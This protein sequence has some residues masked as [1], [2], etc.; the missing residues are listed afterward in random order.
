NVSSFNMRRAEM[1][2]PPKKKMHKGES[3]A[4]TAAEMIDD[5]K[6]FVERFSLLFDSSCFSDVRLRVGEQSYYGHRFILAAASKVFEAMFGDSS[7]WEESRQQEI[8]LVEEEACQ[9]VFYDFL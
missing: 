1:E 8:R 7:A 3:S 9:A 5:S 6:A 2:D 4:S